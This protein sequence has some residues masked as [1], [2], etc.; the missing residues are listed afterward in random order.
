MEFKASYHQERL[1]F[2]DIS[3]TGNLYDPGPI[4]YNIPLI[5]Q[6]R[7]Q[8]D[9]ELLEKSIKAVIDRHEALRT[10]IIT[11]DSQPVQAIAPEAPFKLHKLVLTDYSG[12]DKHTHAAA[13]AINFAQQ[14]FKLGDEFL[15]RGQL[16]QVAMD[17]SILVI[18]IHHIIADR[19]S[20]KIIAR[21]IFT[22]YD[23]FLK[24]KAPDLPVLSAHYADFSQ[25]QYGFSDEISE[26]IL[27]YWKRKMKGK[28]LPLQLPLDKPRSP[29]HIFHDGYRQF[30]LN[31]DLYAKVEKFCNQFQTHKFPVLLA[32][33]K[34]LLYRHTGQEEILVGMCEENRDQPGLDHMVGPIA[35]LLPLRSFLDEKSDFL[36][37]LED[38]KKTVKDA[39]KHKDIPFDKLVLEL[40]PP[41]D[42]SRNVFFDVLFQ[43]EE[44]ENPARVIPS[45]NLDIDILETNLGLGK[46]DLNLLLE[47]DKSSNSIPGILVFNRDYYNESTIDRFITHY[48]NLLDNILEKPDLKISDFYF[49]PAMEK[50]TLLYEF[51][52]T[53]VEIPSHKTIHRLF[54]EQAEKSPDRIA[55]IGGGD[56]H[57]V[58]STYL[59]YYELNE[60]SNRLACLLMQKGVGQDTIVGIIMDSSPDMIIGLLGILKAGGAFL[61]IDPGS[62]AGRVKTMLDD[63][64]ATILVTKSAVIELT[65]F[66]YFQGSPDSHVE[67]NRT[68][69]RPP[70]TDL[71]SIQ[72]P[73]RSLVDYERYSRDIAE[74]MVKHSIS[75][76][77]TRGCPYNCA[78]CCRIWPRKFVTRS[79]ENIFQELMIYYRMG[80]RRFAFY[81]DIFNLDVKNSSRF[82]DMIIE[83]DLKV[84]LFFPTGFRGDILS[85]EY[86]DLVVRAGAVNIALS[87][88][89]A[90]PRIQKLIR[91]N[92]NIGRFRENV[93]YLCENYP[94]VILELQLMH[95]FPT[96]TEEEAMMSL[97]FVKSMKWIHFPYIHILKIHANTDMEK[98]ALANGIS[99]GAIERSRS[100]A[101]HELPETLPFDKN[102]TL[103]YQAEFLND[104]FLSKERLMQVLP[105]QIKILTRDE[106]V[107]K[108]DSYLPTDINSFEGLLEFIG[109]T[110]EELG[111]TELLEDDLVI[112]PNLNEKMKNYFHP[113]EVE[114]STDALRILLLDLTQFFSEEGSM[115]FD[116]LEPPL[117]LIYLMT[118][119]NRHFGS[120][121][122]GKISKSRLD[123]D[124][125]AALKRLL[126]E[127]KPDV[128]GLRSM[129]FYK[130]LF[131]KTAAVIR[132]WGVDIP[133]IAGGPYATSDFQTVLKDRN[134]DLVVLGEG[135][136]TLR[137]LVEKIMGN[138]KKMPSEKVLEEIRGIAFVPQTSSKVN[139][140]A[141]EIIMLDQFQMSRQRLA[142]GN[143][144]PSCNPGDL[145]YTI[146]TSGSSGKPKGV[147]LEH[148]SLVNLCT[149]HNTYYS[150]TCCDKATK[151]AGFGFDASVWE[152]F[153]Y[154]ISGASLLMVPDEKK[155]DIIRLKNYFEQ[156]AVTI[157][158]L[159][160]QFCQQ[161]IEA[162]ERISSLRVLLTGGDKLNRFIKRHYTLY[163]NYGPTE[164][165]VVTTSFLIENQSEN[166]PI[167]QPIYN[168]RV[169][170][171]DKSSL[172]LQPIG[173]PGELCIGGESLARGYLNNPELTTEKFIFN[174][175]DKSYKTY[176]LYKTGD[177][178]RWLPNGNIEF[179]GRIDQQVKIRGYRV[180]LGEIENQLINCSTVKDVVVIDRQDNNGDKYLCA[181]VVLDL[182]GSLASPVSSHPSN[183]D[184]VKELKDYLS[185]RLP[186]YMS[187]A[188]FVMMDKIPLNDSGKVDRKSLPEPGIT[189]GLEYAVPKNEI[190]WGLV[191]IL[192]E[193]MGI[194]PGTISVRANIFDI[195]V[196][197]ITLVKIA[198]RITAEFNA[199]IDI[200]ILF[201]SSTVEQIAV[202]VQKK[203]IPTAI[204]RLV[205]LNRGNADRNLF[206]QSGDGGIYIFKVLAGLLEDRYNVYGILAR[207]IYDNGP[208]PE[209]RNEIFEECIREIKTVQP[210]GPYLIGGHCFGAI[211]SY[212]LTRELE[213][214]GEQVEKL[215][216]FDEPALMEE[217]ILD[218]FNRFLFAKKIRKIKQTMK[219]IFKSKPGDGKGENTLQETNEKVNLLPED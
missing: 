35:N 180:E 191:Y 171:L 210:G 68:A 20:L 146:F 34:L 139:R 92:L 159:P 63:C 106:I 213:D 174:R 211:I 22:Y 64:R 144:L 72:V 97:D 110:R 214:R 176:I 31:G 8:I 130:E 48:L 165:T 95:G 50:K 41:K 185:R 2:I 19:Y 136:E 163:N 29:I 157:G 49:L 167:G 43:Y 122:A 39:Q 111:I 11:K 202:D 54:E 117:G 152:I 147:A 158:F 184:P 27:L 105:H 70:I 100:L 161:F 156:H 59:T 183:S 102:F 170:I 116:V 33:F 89:T 188:Y 4:Y 66:S 76:Q 109:I 71:N 132:Q 207:G 200:S 3:E 155:L 181:Y 81:D 7:G 91:K 98:I 150:V 138:N 60:C 108:Y 179:L 162:F 194:D 32:I 36:T 197:S 195:G 135:E 28:L 137:E 12:E 9:A 99:R 38:I 112:V 23:A 129:T 75:M 218:H 198:H 203:F 21:E 199:Q 119:L 46:Y 151:Y 143:L 83:S 16:I 53:K 67:F 115:L 134:I 82:F 45:D 85:R 118:H 25:W 168:N 217:K 80:V 6:V 189:A 148:K 42:T 149:W 186:D 190:E 178:A 15:C 123:F 127:F 103:K 193:I 177:L 126:D 153:P 114:T 18:S 73:D 107:Q 131:H 154:L 17:E 215:I 212:E 187:P 79:A 94:H 192:S 140:F 84:Q 57:H 62:P 173:I 160:T 201:T 219:R 113:G 166:I 26:P 175:S 205:L 125:F 124:S 51:N 1:W 87:L 133:V 88:E 204:K 145:A 96:E 208:L 52:D 44:N 128:I 47:N 14:P 30:I 101:Y 69:P 74:A 216:I 104:Y 24:G 65:N 77:A 121:I 142:A 90:S 93:Q 40:N 58:R 5:F 86:I 37:F 55:L 13:L 10:R 56:S 172:Y 141:R 78:Y 196:N 206:I 182:S 61:P 164:N 169:F 120:K 209:N